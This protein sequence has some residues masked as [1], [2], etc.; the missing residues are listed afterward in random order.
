MDNTRHT[1]GRPMNIMNDRHLYSVYF[2]PRGVVRM[3]KWDR[4]LRPGTS[5]PSTGS[6]ASGEAGSGKSMLVGYV[7][8][9]R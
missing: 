8:G 2:A 7:S 5:V 4:P 6:S 9:L 1:G 3:T